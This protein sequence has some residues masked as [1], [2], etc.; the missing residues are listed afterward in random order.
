MFEYSANQARK[1]DPPPPKATSEREVYFENAD[2][3]IVTPCFERNSLLPGQEIRGPAIIEQLDTTTPI[4][5]NDI[6][7]VTADGHIIIS[8]S[9]EDGKSNG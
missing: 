2:E 8:I 9:H 4:Y 5:P 3:P 6:A 7:K 1:N